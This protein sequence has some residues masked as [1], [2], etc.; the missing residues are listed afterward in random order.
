MSKKREEEQ[1]QEEIEQEIRRV[2]L[3]RGNQ[4]IGILDQRLG[5][6][7]TR[8]NCLDGKSRICRGVCPKRH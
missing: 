4:V 5:A 6:S 3:P 2:K 1:K 7:R 8:V